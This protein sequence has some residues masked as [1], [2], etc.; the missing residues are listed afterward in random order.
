MSKSA[1]E[2]RGYYS[3]LQ[4]VPDPERAEG[5][6]IGVIL[7]CPEKNFLRIRTTV[8]SDRVRRFFGRRPDTDLNLSRLN[9]FKTA[10]EERV[11]IEAAR[12]RTLEDF[13]GFIKTRANQLR[14]TEPRPVK[15]EDPE[16]E[17]SN[18]YELLVEDTRRGAAPTPR[19]TS[20]IKARF[21]ELIKQRGL[22][23]VVQKNVEIELP[24]LGEKRDYPFAFL[25]GQRNVIEPVS[26]EAISQRDITD[27][28]C[29]LA[30]EGQDLGKREDP[31][32]LNVIGSFRPDQPERVA[33]IRTLLAENQVT[34]HTAEEMEELVEEIAATAHG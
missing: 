16:S 33:Q 2:T 28:A 7:F 24:L 26:F 31:I 4:Y 25:N 19:S 12:M 6:N 27:R 17:L 13:R 14:L 9:A 21:N 10:F 23:S 34:L 11:A 30:I 18:L 20:Q 29:R 5:V 8:R 3:I 15:L 1:K 32:K 22:E